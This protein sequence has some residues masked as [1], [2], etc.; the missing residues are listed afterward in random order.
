[1]H[2]ITDQMMKDLWD[3]EKDGPWILHVWPM[4]WAEH[5]QLTCVHDEGTWA[6]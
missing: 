3:H 5:T 6:G 2:K 4:K 1:M